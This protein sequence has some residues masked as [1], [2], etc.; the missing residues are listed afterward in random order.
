MF[1]PIEV[2]V[3]KLND[4]QSMWQLFGLPVWLLRAYRNMRAD[5][6]NRKE[7]NDMITGAALYHNALVQEG[8]LVDE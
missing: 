5:G 8:F 1:E 4:Y 3:T 6:V 2:R 7:S